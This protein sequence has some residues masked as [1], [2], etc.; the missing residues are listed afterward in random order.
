MKIAKFSTQQGWISLPIIALIL[1]V[2]ALSIRYQ[3][4]LFA[5]YKWRA[6]LSDVADEQEIWDAFRESFVAAPS[7]S[8]ATI[9]DCEGFCTLDTWQNTTQEKSWHDDDRSLD[10]QW[11]VYVKE[12][13]EDDGVTVIS[14]TTSYRLCATQNQQAYLCWWW[15]NGKRLAEGWVSVD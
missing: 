4:A 13:T 14:T 3:E 10:Y 6:Q 9:S 12:E 5:S 15:R 8:A 2:S 1:S 7:F 11:M